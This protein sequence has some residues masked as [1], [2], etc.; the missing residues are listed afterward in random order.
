MTIEKKTDTWLLGFSAGCS[1]QE[2]SIVRLSLSEK[3]LMAG[4]EGKPGQWENA[5]L[6]CESGAGHRC[7]IKE[8][9]DGGI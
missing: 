8:N 1:C 4:K 2:T 3:H 6:K 9:S 7:S 5:V